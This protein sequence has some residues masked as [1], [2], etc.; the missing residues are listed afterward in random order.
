MGTG[1]KTENIIW[2]SLHRRLLIA[3]LAMVGKSYLVPISN[4]TSLSR[5]YF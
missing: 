5:I 2:G 4:S 1:K 3:I